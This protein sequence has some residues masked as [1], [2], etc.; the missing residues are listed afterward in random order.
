MRYV[1]QKGKY[2]RL[3]GDT[4]NYA[5]AITLPQDNIEDYE[6]VDKPIPVDEELIKAKQDKRTE[7]SQTCE[8]TI[9][10]GIDVNEEHFSLTYNDQINLSALYEMVKQG[11]E[12]AL[13]HAD[14]QLC[15][16]FTA[17]EIVNLMAKATEF[18][19]YNTTYCNHLFA[20]LNRIETVDEIQAIQY[21]IALPEDLQNHMNEV[22]GVETTT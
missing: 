16:P 5:V 3:K 15:R 7:I 2:Y 11:A 21:G 9:F 1:A 17:D 10:N 6:L 18:K 4:E 12:T 19:T 20:W 8:Q 13:Y 22:L 14:G